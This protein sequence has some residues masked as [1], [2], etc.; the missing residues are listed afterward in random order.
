MTEKKRHE[1]VVGGTGGQGVLTV[2]YVLAAAAAEVYNYVTRFPIYMAT[3][4]GG[5]AFATVI[6]SDQEIAAPIL[7]RAEN[8]VAMETGSYGRFKKEVKPGGRLFVN[9]SIVK[10]VDPPGDYQLF[11][12]PATD[13]AKELGKP[14][15]ANVVM[16]GAYREITGVMT[17]EQ[18][19]KALQKD[20]GEG[21]MEVTLEAF[22]RGVQYARDNKMV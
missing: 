19:L 16:L 7:S 22:K 3:Q 12:I 10:K 15:M 6:F 1:L 13:L 9:S 5:P 14:R 2:A 20:V 4:R 11:E 18:V 8:A 21:R 17:E